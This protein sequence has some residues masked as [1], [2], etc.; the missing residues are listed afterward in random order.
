MPRVIA[1]SARRMKLAAPPGEETR[2]TQDIIKET[3]FNII[4]NDIPGAVFADL[5]AGCGSM[6]IEALSRGAKKAY[7]I[8]NEAAPYQ[9][10]T[11]NLHKTHLEDSAVV[12]RK[13]LP[14]ALRF[15]HEKEVDVI[16]MDPPYASD[17]YRLTLDALSQMRYVTPYT[18]II[19]EALR[20]QDFSFVEHY[21]FQIVREKL[22][23]NNKHVFMQKNDAEE[24][25]A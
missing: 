7:F 17:A 1:G 11:Q 25:Y 22:Y 5:Y 6:G 8:E 10:L 14:G 23:K 4:Q 9:C 12:L 24:Q 2:P 13:E 19:A 16:Y 18:I 3:L 21:G 15:I 20:E